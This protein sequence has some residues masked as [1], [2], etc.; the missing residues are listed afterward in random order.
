MPGGMRRRQV[1]NVPRVDDVGNGPDPDG[2]TAPASRGLPEER[3][4]EDDLLP[5]LAGSHRL[6]RLVQV[7]WRPLNHLMKGHSPGRRRRGSPAGTP[8][9]HA[10]DRGLPLHP[11]WAVP[12]PSGGGGGVCAIMRMPHY[13][14]VGITIHDWH[15]GGGGRGV[16]GSSVGSR[17]PP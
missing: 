16:C 13:D 15:G 14:Q 9:G 12:A 11:G 1:L 2:R 7:E 6:V 10:P 17:S 8:S 3:R 4:V 5:R